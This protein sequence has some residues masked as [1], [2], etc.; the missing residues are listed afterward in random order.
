[1]F[2][3]NPKMLNGDNMAMWPQL[4]RTAALVPEDRVRSGCC[5]AAPLN[6]ESSFVV[7]SSVSCVC[8]E[9]TKGPAS[10]FAVNAVGC[11]AESAVHRTV[12]YF[13][14]SKQA[15]AKAVGSLRTRVSG[16]F[17]CLQRRIFAPL[18]EPPL[19]VERINMNSVNYRTHNCRCDTKKTPKHSSFQCCA[20]VAFEVFHKQMTKGSFKTD[21]R[22]LWEQDKNHLHELLTHERHVCQLL[23]LQDATQSW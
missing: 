1:M 23:L 4:L 15:G 7:S 20:S 21:A 5:W 3:L 14:D 18:T 12:A 10:A 2:S 22:F 9:D 11:A 19:P 16:R 13:M 8:S 17:Q 6:S